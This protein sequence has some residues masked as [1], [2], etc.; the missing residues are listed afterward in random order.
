MLSELLCADD[1]V[2]KS[3]TMEGLR[4]KFLE[5][6]EDF[7]SKSVKVKLERAEVMINGGITKDGMSKSNVDQ[8]GSAP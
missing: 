8:C 3:E 6:K 7:E 2:L 4:N 5:W 1:L